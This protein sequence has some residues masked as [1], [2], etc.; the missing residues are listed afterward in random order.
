MNLVPFATLVDGKG[1]ALV[2]SYWLAYFSSGRELVGAGSDL[3]KPASDL[4]LVANPAFD[5]K[6]TTSGSQTVALRSRDFRG[7]FSPLQGTERE[8]Q[9]IPL[10]VAGRQELKQ[11]LVGERAQESAVKTARSPRI[12]H[13]ATHGFFLQDEELALGDETRGLSLLE[14]DLTVQP[15]KSGTTKKYENPL[16]RSGLAFAEANHAS[17]ITD[18]DYGILTAL[19]ITGMD[20]Y[21]TDLV[22]LSACDTGVGEVKAGEVVFSLRRAFAL[23]GA[24]NLL[25]SLWPVS[26]EIT[27]NQ[28]KA[29]YQNFQKLPPAEALRQAQLE[30]IKELKAKDGVASPALWAPF[31]LQGGQALVQ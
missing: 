27:A 26:A 16:V 7:V 29:F 25:M 18:G 13:L 19:E 20:L 24:K 3:P 4:L 22:V 21:G 11:V 23:A 15:K 28:V 30:T 10:L 17:E 31:I 9:E 2:E 1:H 8:S 12:L 6:A 14:R 5:N